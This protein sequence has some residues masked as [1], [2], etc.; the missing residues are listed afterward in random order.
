[1]IDGLYH[2]QLTPNP[3]RQTWWATAEQR[4]DRVVVWGEFNTR[5]SPKLKL[6][7]FRRRDFVAVIVRGLQIAKQ[8]SK[9]SSRV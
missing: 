9:I 7:W 6:Q 3:Y 1:M 8:Q 2:N 5:N 4:S